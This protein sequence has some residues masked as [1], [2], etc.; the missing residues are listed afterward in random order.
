MFYARRIAALLPCSPR[1][2]LMA[3]TVNCFRVY[4][5]T[6]VFCARSSQ[7]LLL[8]LLLLLAALPKVRFNKCWVWDSLVIVFILFQRKVLKKSE[9]KT[10][11]TPRHSPGPPRVPPGPSRRPETEAGV[12]FQ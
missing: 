3:D 2:G 1:A 9:K 6:S 4:F 11:I 10:G 7:K 12:D 8:L 5:H